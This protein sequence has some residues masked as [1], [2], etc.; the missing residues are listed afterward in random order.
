METIQIKY[1]DK[2][3]DKLNKTS[4]GDWIDLRAAEA[5]ELKEGEYRLIKLGIGMRL[6]EGYEAH[7]IPRSSTFSNFG[8][9]Q[10]NHFGL[11][12]NIYCGDN[13]EW[14]FPAMAM[15]DTVIN[16]NDRICQ[17]RIEKCQPKITFEEVE[18]LST[19]SRGGVGSTGIK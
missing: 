10:T 9:I 5:V 17:F 15:R 19:I 3:I 2:E 18:S 12:D 4:K 8:V 6:P 14:M 13:D 1:F 16:K 11:I 7:V